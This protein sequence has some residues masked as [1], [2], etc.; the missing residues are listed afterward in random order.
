MSESTCKNLALASWLRRFA[1]GQEPFDASQII[2]A[3]S[4]IEYLTEGLTPDT[5]KESAK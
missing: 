2:L 1:R 5:S 3:A 4:A